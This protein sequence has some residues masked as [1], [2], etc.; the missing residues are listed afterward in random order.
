MRRA[1]KVDDNQKEIVKAFRDLGCSVQH[2]HTVGKGCP[3]L[4]VGVYKVNVMVEVKDANKP[5][6]KRELTDDEKTWHEAWKGWV[7]VV[8][9]VEDC[10]ALVNRVARQ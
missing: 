10:I 1:A 4:V 5:K 2:L 7:E 6:S 3:D 9:T 8:E